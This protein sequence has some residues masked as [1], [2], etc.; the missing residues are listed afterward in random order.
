MTMTRNK[1][2]KLLKLLVCTVQKMLKSSK[3]FSLS[4]IA[5]TFFSRNVFV[6]KKLK[7]YYGN[8][9]VKK[10]FFNR[11]KPITFN[12]FK[13]LSKFVFNSYFFSN[14]IY[15]HTSINRYQV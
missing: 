9:V 7:Y 13:K 2:F 14:D 4:K 5:K 6:L 8:R 3:F 12:M 15:N 1:N 10:S 11:Y